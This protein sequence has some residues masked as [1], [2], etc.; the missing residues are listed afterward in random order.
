V[1]VLNLTGR[2]FGRLVVLERAAD[3]YVAPSGKRF[4]CWHVLCDCGT[5]TTI[6]GSQMRSGRTRSCGCLR[7]EAFQEAQ[8]ERSR[9]IDLI[10]QRFG[11]LI[12]VERAADY[13]RPSDGRCDV[14]WRAACDC[15]GETV[16]SGTCLRLGLTTSC[17][18]RRGTTDDLTGSVYARLTVIERAGSLVGP[19]G[20]RVALWRCRCECGTE[21]VVA[22]ARLRNG[23]TRSCGCL[24]REATAANG[25]ANAAIPGEPG[26]IAAH[27]RV[28][29]L[30]GVA[31]DYDCADCG[32]T[33]QH[34][35]Y[36]HDDPDERIGPV[37]CSGKVRML[38]WSNDPAHYS[39]RCAKCHKRFDRDWR[40][41]VKAS[42]SHVP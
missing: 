22:T 7:T 33:A 24:S 1:P 40:A 8:A 36:D 38:P 10:G 13:V 35:S 19:S 25:R 28:S 21:T 27:Q 16:T 12:V 23:Q 29:R 2:R 15:G 18:C 6:R 41:T 17:G 26:Y 37:V 5:Q 32:S 42:S 14:R 3:D 34:W 9:R 39:P 20:S 31:S 30:H 4:P 11:D